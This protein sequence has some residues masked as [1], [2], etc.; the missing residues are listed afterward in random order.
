M[1]LCK[2]QQEALNQLTLFQLALIFILLHRQMI[3]N[4]IQTETPENKLLLLIM[5]HLLA[6]IFILL[7]KQMI[8]NK[9]QTGIQ[10]NKLLLLNMPLPSVLHSMGFQIQS[11]RLNRIQTETLKKVMVKKIRQIG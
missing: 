1:V 8:L 3:L 6:Q 5:A 2:I 11:K 4:K 10:E 9:M 7:H